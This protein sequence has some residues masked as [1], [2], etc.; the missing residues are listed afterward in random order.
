[1]KIEI[2]VSD[3]KKT[4]AIK[5]DGSEPVPMDNFLLLTQEGD[6][7]RNLVFGNVE[8]VGRL[9]YGFYVNCLRLEETG[10]RDVLELVAEDIRDG[11]EL[12]D[13]ASEETIRRLM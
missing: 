2:I 12:R 3:D 1:M 6:K 11:K 10:M 13:E 9:L 5:I 4:Y 7:T 8:E